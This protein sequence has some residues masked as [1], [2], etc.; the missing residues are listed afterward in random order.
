[1]AHSVIEEISL[2][3][4]PEFASGEFLP[5]SDDARHLLVAGK[6]CQG[7]QMIGHQQDQVHP[8][9]PAPLS[10]TNRFEQR[11]R[12][13]GVTELVLTAWLTTDC[14]KEN[15]IVRSNSGWNRVSQLSA[16]RSRRAEAS[17]PYL[18]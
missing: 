2:P 6:G 8:P 15:F 1:L 3:K 9:I 18:N 7:V 14:Q 17:A 11:R 4:N 10:K 5:L 16:S 13:L 12:Q